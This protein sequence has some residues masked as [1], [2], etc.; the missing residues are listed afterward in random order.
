MRAWRVCEDCGLE[1]LAD[2]ARNGCP[3]C[4]GATTAKSAAAPTA[5]E[6]Y[7]ARSA[8]VASLM[9]WL[10][11]ELE[12]HG[13]FARKEGY[14]FGHSGD[15]GHLRTKLIEALAFMAQQDEKDIKDALAESACSPD[16]GETTD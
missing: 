12:E 1:W 3:G 15:L 8:D 5:E 11:M 14:G 2:D 7:R 6:L 9:A 16:E 13:R 4:G 10:E